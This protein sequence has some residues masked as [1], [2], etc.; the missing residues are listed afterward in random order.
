ME[1]LHLREIESYNE[2]R[3]TVTISWEAIKKFN[4][5]KRGYKIY[6]STQHSS[7]GYK[8]MD[9][10]NYTIDSTELDIDCQEGKVT[11]WYTIA[12]FNADFTGDLSEPTSIT[13]CIDYKYET[14]IYSVLIGT[15]V[16]F[17]III[18]L[19]LRA[20]Y[21]QYRPAGPQPH[22]VRSQN[23][24]WRSDDLPVV[25]SAR[26]PRF[27]RGR[28]KHIYE[29]IGKRRKVNVE[30]GQNEEIMLTTIQSR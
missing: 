18:A 5:P 16:V 3:C 13:L 25:E 26:R 22:R 4:G 29:K 17:L 2:R 6:N 23:S 15:F 12:A 24:T 10:V 14:I 7:Y 27:S 19:L 30:P 20:K 9:S 1:R 8:L 28:K 21:L 11:L